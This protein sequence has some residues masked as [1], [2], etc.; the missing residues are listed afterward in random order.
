MFAVIRHTFEIVNPEPENPKSYNIMG[1]WKHYV[2]LYEN[3]EDATSFAITLLE[4]PL[5]K[6][7]DDYMAH[8]IESLQ[9]NRYWQTGRESVAIA[10]VLDSPEIIYGEYEDGRENHIH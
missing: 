10:E 3:E 9:S 6:A 7:N 5:L 1:E 2:W 8:A 4:S